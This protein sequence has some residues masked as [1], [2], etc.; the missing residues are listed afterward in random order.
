MSSI[1]W[2]T[3]VD[4]VMQH[5][6]FYD[7]SDSLSSSVEVLDERAILVKIT[8]WVM[9]LISPETAVQDEK[10]QTGLELH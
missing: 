7:F 2:K 4:F 6:I 1:Q 9:D 5:I 8:K 3:K 10:D